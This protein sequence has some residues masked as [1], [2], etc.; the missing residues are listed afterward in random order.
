MSKRSKYTAEEKYKILMEY[1][2]GGGSIEEIA[3]KHRMCAST[4]YDWRFNYNEYGLDGLMESRIRNQY[5]EELKIKAVKDY[6][7]G[8]YSQGEI[9]KKYNI[10]CKS[11]LKQWVNKYNSHRETTSI[12]KGMSKSMTKGRTTSWEEKIEVVLYYIN[13]SKD[14][15]RTAETYNVSYQQVYQ[16]IKKYE[17]GGQDALKDGRGRK[18]SEEELTPDE[19]MKLAMKKLEVENERLRAENAFLKKL[20]ELERGRF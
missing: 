5:S 14:Y 4:F 15:Q 9:I 13:H 7:S 8:Q 1:E 2:N 18:K 3:L 17:L 20:E 6:M 12:T 16:W 19:K 11:V 10:S